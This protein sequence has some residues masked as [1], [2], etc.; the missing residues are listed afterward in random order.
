MGLVAVVNILASIPLALCNCQVGLAAVAD[1]LA[2]IPRALCSC[3]NLL[4]RPPL[5]LELLVQP[6]QNHA[7]RQALSCQVEVASKIWIQKLG[8][9]LVAGHALVRGW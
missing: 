4:M 6:Q 1:I 8:Q 7:G 5:D 3:Q 2:S 9:Q